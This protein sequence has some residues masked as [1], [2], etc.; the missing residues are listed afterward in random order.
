MRLLEVILSVNVCQGDELKKAQNSLRT[1]K[2]MV[3]GEQRKCF[4]S[5]TYSHGQIAHVP[6]NDSLSRVEVETYDFFGKSVVSF[7]ALLSQTCGV[8]S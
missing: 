3:A 2:R 5:G 6:I 8:F 4:L 7:G 1:Y